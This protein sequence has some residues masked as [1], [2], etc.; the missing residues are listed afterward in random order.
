M[1]FV[2]QVVKL[3][4]DMAESVKNLVDFQKQQSTS[5]D[6]SSI[7]SLNKAA[8]RM[9]A[10]PQSPLLDVTEDSERTDE[11]ALND[12]QDILSITG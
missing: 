10:S 1:C 5:S 3:K 6:A 4:K 2:V 8:R 7:M 12:L 9:S 11:L